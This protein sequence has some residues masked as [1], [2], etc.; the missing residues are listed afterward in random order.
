MCSLHP[1]QAKAFF[2]STARPQLV[3]LTVFQRGSLLESPPSVSV[4]NSVPRA[5]P[6]LPADS[7]KSSFL[8]ERS[9]PRYV[10]NSPGKG[11]PRINRT[12]T[13]TTLES[14]QSRAT[15]ALAEGEREKGGRR[16][17][18]RSLYFPEFTRSPL[19]PLV[20]FSFNFL[21]GAAPRNESSSVCFYNMD[22][23][24]RAGRGGR[25]TQ[26]RDPH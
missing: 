18:N 20:C 21:A 17:K 15:N 5:P 11:D 19:L 23:P 9:V 2:V 1:A 14:K 10:A 4:Y 24:M 13:T 7:N 3:P 6:P 8:A 26:I 12:Q 16:K 22:C 25:K